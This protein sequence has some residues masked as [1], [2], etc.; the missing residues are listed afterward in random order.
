MRAKFPKAVAAV[1]AVVV[2]AGHRQTGRA[3]SRGDAVAGGG[4]LAGPPAD[5][6]GERLERGKVERPALAVLAGLGRVGQPPK[7]RRRVVVERKQMNPP[8]ADIGECGVQR[9]EVVGLPAQMHPHVAGPASGGQRVQQHPPGLDAAQARLPGQGDPVE[10]GGDAVGEQLPLGL[11]K[12]QADREVDAGPRLHLPL[13]GIAVDVDDPRQHQQAAGVEIV[14]R[15]AASQ[16]GDHA[17][18]QQQIALVQ[19]PA[20]EHAPAGDPE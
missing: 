17:V 13:E 7:D 5:A 10:G 20:R 18:F 15:R 6:F 4:H 8:G 2:V 3:R 16:R 1:D 19:P 11:G 12:R 9:I 14:T